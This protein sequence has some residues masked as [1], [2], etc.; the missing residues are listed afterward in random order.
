MINRVSQ[1]TISGY[2]L[3]IGMCDRENPVTNS[4]CLFRQT[5]PLIMPC[6]SLSCEREGPHARPTHGCA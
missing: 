3:D 1:V 2:G 6:G 5:I 4:C